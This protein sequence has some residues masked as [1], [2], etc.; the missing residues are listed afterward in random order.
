MRFQKVGFKV[1]LHRVQ[2]GQSG[3][4]TDFSCLQREGPG[5]LSKWPR[6]SRH[7][8]PPQC[9]A[10]ISS[11]FISSC[12]VSACM[13]CGGGS[14]FSFVVIPSESSGRKLIMLV[15]RVLARYWRKLELKIQASL[16]VENKLRERDDQQP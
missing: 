5:Y 10:V 11:M 16:Q 8:H 6:T 9:A 2:A 14:R 15:W 7:K 12:S 3:N 13:A 4:Q 1:S